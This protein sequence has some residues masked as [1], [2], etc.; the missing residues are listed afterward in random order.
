MTIHKNAKL[1]PF[2]AKTELLVPAGSIEKLK[3]LFIMA[4]IVFISELPIY[5][6]ELNLNLH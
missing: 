6:L 4:L 2:G 1:T 5:R 3:L